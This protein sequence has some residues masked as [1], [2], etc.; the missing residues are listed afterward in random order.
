MVNGLIDWDDFEKVNIITGTILDVEDF[1]E[2]RIP[3]YKVTVDFG[4]DY[5][6]RTTSARITD[7]YPKDTLIGKQIIGIVNF[8]GKQIGPFI[9]EFLLTGFVNTDGSVVLAI[10]ERKVENGMRLK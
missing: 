2:A 7:L 3:A 10:P 1:P 8:P 4:K 5:G 6:I 9:S